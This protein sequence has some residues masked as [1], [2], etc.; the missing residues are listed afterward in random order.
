MREVAASA[1][2]DLAVAYGITTLHSSIK[3]ICPKVDFGGLAEWNAG[4]FINGGN[5]LALYRRSIWEQHEFDEN[6]ITSEDLAWFLW[7]VTSGHRAAKVRDAVGFY[8]NQGSIRHMFLKGWNE[9]NLA[10]SLLGNRIPAYTNTRKILLFAINFA[11]LAK[12][13]AQQQITFRTFIR[14]VSHACGSF[15]AGILSKIKIHGEPK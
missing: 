14:Q 12:L 7:A 11:H 4:L 13:L 9:T 1:P 15:L 10:I 5:A 2:P 8:R 6:L 3:Q